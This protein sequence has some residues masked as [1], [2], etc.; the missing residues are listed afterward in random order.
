LHRKSVGGRGANGGDR[1][2]QRGVCPWC[3]RLEKLPV[4]NKKAIVYPF[5]M[6]KGFE[7]AKGNYGG[8]L[9]LAVRAVPGA[10]N[11][12]DPGGERDGL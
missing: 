1:K 2:F 5:L 3:V 9:P 6:E 4:E 7:V 11:T 12:K 8:G 10:L